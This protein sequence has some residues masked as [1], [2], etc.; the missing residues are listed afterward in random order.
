MHQA[1]LG[2]AVVNGRPKWFIR[3]FCSVDFISIV[4]QAAGGAMASSELSHVTF[5]FLLLP[6]TDSH[7]SLFYLQAP[8]PRPRSTARTPW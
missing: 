8:T 6:E 2:R 5:L 7:P 4:I 1:D 3:I